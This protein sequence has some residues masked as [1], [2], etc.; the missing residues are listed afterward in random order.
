MEMS[1]MLE[2]AQEFAVLGADL[3][4]DGD[5]DAAL[6]RAVELAVKHVPGC[7]WAS[8]THLRH[9]NARTLASSDPVAALADQLQY[10]LGEGPCLQAAQDG[11]DYLLVDVAEDTRW[12]DYANAVQ[13]RSPVRSVLSFQLPAEE[14]AALNLFAETAGAFTDESVTFG[15]VFAAHVSTLVALFEAEESATHLQVAVA[16][17]RQIGTAIGVLMAHH[18]ITAESAFNLLRTASQNLHVKLRD[19]ARDVVETGELPTSHRD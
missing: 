6:V 15:A 10:D 3:H 19:I 14:H 18:K 12:P 4:G 5:N 16:S 9:G 11:Q 1:G 17:N 13:Q 8:I 2:L 7:S